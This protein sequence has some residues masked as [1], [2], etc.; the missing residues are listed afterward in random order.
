MIEIRTHGRGGQGSVIA[1]EILADAF[2][3]EGKYVQAFPAFGVERRGAPVVAF[4]R[5]S[6]EE[7]RERCQIYEPDHLIV[8]DAVLIDTV[9]ITE[10]LKKGGW[11]VINTNRPVENGEL[12][13]NYHIATVDANQIALRHNLGSRAAP[14]VNTAIIGAF[15]GATKL[16]SL[17]AVKQAIDGF[18]PLKK[19]ENMQAAEDAFNAVKIIS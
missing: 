13:G 15:S 6:D 18:V 8:L 7:V 14:I 19:E 16:V 5:V 4:T 11:I 17:D 2:F 1:S 3:N 12:M 10:G 9:N